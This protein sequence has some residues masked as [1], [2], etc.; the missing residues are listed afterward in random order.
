LR[1]GRVKW[2]SQFSVEEREKL[3]DLYSLPEIFV[4]MGFS[5]AA[6]QRNAITQRN[7]TTIGS[8]GPRA[9]VQRYIPGSALITE[10]NEK[11]STSGGIGQ[12]LIMTKA[13]ELHKRIQ[14]AE[15][16]RNRNYRLGLIRELHDPMPAWMLRGYENGE[17]ELEGDED[18]AMESADED[19]QLLSKDTADLSSF[20]KIDCSGMSVYD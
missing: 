15:E 3:Q 10:G 2:S 13:D 19:L 12:Q 17:R 20:A 8:Y 4:R 14:D 11:V 1:P 5:T 7:G 6:D 9:L 16:E 18:Y